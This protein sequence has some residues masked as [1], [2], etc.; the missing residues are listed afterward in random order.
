MNNDAPI[1]ATF[2]D[3]QKT[4]DFNILFRNLYRY[5]IRNMLLD[6]LKDYLTNRI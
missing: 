4:Y 5:G 1:I 3:L 2:L 6:L